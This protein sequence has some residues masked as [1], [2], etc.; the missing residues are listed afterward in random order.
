MATSGPGAGNAPPGPADRGTRSADGTPGRAAELYRALA[1]Q[2]HVGVLFLDDRLRVRDAIHTPLNF[3][4]LVIRAGAGVRLTDLVPEDDRESVAAHLR[5]VLATGYP[6]VSTAHQTWRMRT[7]AGLLYVAMT[8]LRSV[9]ADGNPSLVVTLINTTDDVQR[10]QRLEL[11][12]DAAERIGLQLD[13]VRTA[14]QLADVLV[15]RL[16]DVAVIS[17]ADEIPEGRE[18]PTRTGGGDLALWRAAIAPAGE[19]RPEGY[20]RPARD[21]R[22]AHVP[23]F[24]RGPEVIR[25]FQAG[26]HFTLVGRAATTAVVDDEPD[27]VRALVPFAEEEGSLTVACLP[28]LTERGGEHNPADPGLVLG[29]VELW[30][31][32]EER[33]F[34]EADVRTGKAI[35]SRAA[36]SLDNARRYNLERRTSLALQRS[37]LPPA[38]TAAAA[39]STAAVYVP[40]RSGRGLGGDFYDAIELSSKRVALVAGDIAGHGL[41]AAATMG[42]IRTAVRTLAAMDLAPGELLTHLN[43]L[44]VELADGAAREESPAGSSCLYAVYD[45]IT[46]RCS[47]ASAGHPPPIAIRPDGAADYLPVTPGDPLGHGA[48]VFDVAETDLAP[49]TVLALYS[50]GLVGLEGVRLPERLSAALM[51]ADGELHGA[52]EGVVAA[53]PDTSLA[54]DVT[55]LLARTRAIADDDTVA[56]PIPH[57]PAAVGDARDR[58]TR[59]LQDWGLDDLAF[60]TELIVSE[61]VTNGIRHAEPPVV[62]RLIR[63]HDTLVCEVTDG[64]SSAPH[65]TRAP[66]SAE[67][68]R[69]LMIT[70]Q[71]VAGRWGVRYDSTGGKA[72]WAE[73]STTPFS[74]G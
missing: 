46:C 61:L 66:D 9:D 55:L 20:I 17:L 36:V 54:D 41:H 70:A 69:G 3:G 57:D 42:R 12:Q 13:V 26:Q 25:M 38:A 60:T 8:V 47:I 34:D 52:A 56:W 5:A 15:P 51:T 32:G 30:R 21:S 39:A 58:T 63:D 68:G 74:E 27:M 53:L 23:P 40:A 2:P 37:L 11:L 73:Q 50:D 28:L 16:C 33:P 62:L 35:V 67:G 6:S 48:V 4:G 29:S 18:P 22:D 7:P 65:L 1:L 10:A 72:I 19:P 59:Q 49:G 24:L 64:S 43:E 44:V 45:P 31:R 14:Q 71:L